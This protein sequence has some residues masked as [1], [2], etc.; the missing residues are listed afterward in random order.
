MVL[1]VIADW[2]LSILPILDYSIGANEPIITIEALHKK[3]AAVSHPGSDTVF[4]RGST[5]TEPGAVATGLN[6]LLG[7]VW[8]HLY[9]CSEFLG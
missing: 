1:L 6:T 8:L 7:V 9:A 3:S 4:N 5:K 2:R